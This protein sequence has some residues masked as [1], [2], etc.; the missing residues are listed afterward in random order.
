MTVVAPTLALA[1]AIELPQAEIDAVL[2]HLP[3]H[4]HSVTKRIGSKERELLVPSDELKRIQRRLL[5]RVFSR[6]HPHEASH[7]RRG[8][9]ILTNA[10]VHLGNPFVSVRDITGAFPAVKPHVVRAALSRAL[11]RGKMNKVLADPITQLCTVREQLPQ[12]APT[13]TALLDLVLY[14]IDAYMARESERRGFRYS[15]YVDDFCISGETSPKA[16]VSLLSRELERRHFKLNPS[17]T[18]DWVPGKRATVNGLVLAKA[19]ILRA[20]Y[21]RAV[22]GLIDRHLDGTS[23]LSK[24]ALRVLRGRVGWIRQI[25]P[26]VGKAL[27]ERLGKDDA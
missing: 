6:L 9:S 22:R 2:A 4:Y 20:D 18:R 24:D 17:K 25:H 15:R 23:R 3:S 12:G 1:A 27:G 8:R 7:C 10:R 16:L 13:S 26:R 19:P 14:P 11:T 21:V 5:H